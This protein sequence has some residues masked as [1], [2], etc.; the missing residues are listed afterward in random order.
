[1]RVFVSTVS[2]IKVYIYIYIYIDLTFI[3]SIYRDHYIIIGTTVIRK[4][5]Q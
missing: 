3:S 4:Y 2:E 1:M 5:M